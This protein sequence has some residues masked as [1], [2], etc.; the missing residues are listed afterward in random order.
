MSSP[1]LS[2]RWLHEP[3]YIALTPFGETPTGGY[4]ARLRSRSE[5]LEG[6]AQSG[7]TPAHLARM[8]HQGQLI[9]LPSGDETSLQAVLAELTIRTPAP[10]QQVPEYDCA[11][12]RVPDRPGRAI[13]VSSAT[14]QVLAH[15]ATN[16]LGASVRIVADI[17]HVD[18][19]ALW[20]G[21]IHDL[22]GV[23]SA[24]VGVV[25]QSATS[26]TI[27]SPERSA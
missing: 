13:A 15:S 18:R 17:R 10:H 14:A 27:N 2:L 12:L 20:R 24:G 16:S 4:F 5:I 19:D 23:L 7:G 25:S 9:E 3:A 6:L 8:V 22:T 21:V 1:I 11:L 26:P